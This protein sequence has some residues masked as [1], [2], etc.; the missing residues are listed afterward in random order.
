MDPALVT[1]ILG[2]GGVAAIMPKVIDGLI[3]W[4]NGRALSE[5]RQN[6]SILERLAEADKRA[7]NE[8][9]FRRALEEYAGVLR[10]LLVQAGMAIERIPPWP[11]RK[12]PTEK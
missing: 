11:I 2:V 6:Q 4:R 1:A 10:L 7:E 9:D 3:A 12:L 5:K 8:A